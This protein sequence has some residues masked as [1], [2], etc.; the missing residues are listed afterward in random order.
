MALGNGGA[1]VGQMEQSRMRLNPTGLP[2]PPAVST[3]V[4]QRIGLISHEVSTLDDGTQHLH[5]LLSQLEER[6]AA[7]LMVEPPNTA[8]DVAGKPS[9][10]VPLAMG[11]AEA[12][13]RLRYACERL[14]RMIARIEL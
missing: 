8:G 9:A 3:N 7:V 6:L 10:P 12:N 2:T 14:E 4:P 1:M 13:A 11:L 5:A